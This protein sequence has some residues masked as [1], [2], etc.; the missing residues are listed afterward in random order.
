MTHKLGLS[1]DGIKTQTTTE[2]NDSDGERDER[3]EEERDEVGWMNVTSSGL[4]QASWRGY[5][6]TTVGQILSSLILCSFC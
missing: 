1:I 5:I 6:Q 2:H 4:K 3:E